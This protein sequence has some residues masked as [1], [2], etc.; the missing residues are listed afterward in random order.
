MQSI[1][2][3]ILIIQVINIIFQSFN[4]S[5]FLFIQFNLKYTLSFNFLQKVLNIL[6]RMILIILMNLRKLNLKLSYFLPNINIR[7]Y[8]KVFSIQTRKASISF[9]FLIGIIL[10]I[11]TTFNIIISFNLLPTAI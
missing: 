5:S 3:F 1:I 6:L 4:L 2:F 10:I 11:Y 9:L 8:L 7:I